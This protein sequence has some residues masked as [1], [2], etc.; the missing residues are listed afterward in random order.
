MKR[1]RDVCLLACSWL[2]QGVA[3]TAPIAASTVQAMD[4]IFYPFVSYCI[5]VNSS[6]CKPVP[7]AGEAHNDI[8]TLYQL[9]HWSIFK[10]IL[11]NL[12]IFL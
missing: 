3:G 7:A 1:N 6:L 2:I 11:K 5:P 8:H 9:S 4:G 12:K 10:T